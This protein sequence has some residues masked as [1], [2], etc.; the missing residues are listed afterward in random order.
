MTATRGPF[1]SG[2]Y[3][4]A[5]AQSTTSATLVTLTMPV[6][7]NMAFHTLADPASAPV[8]EAAARAPCSLRPPFHRMTGFRRA[9][10]RATSKKRRPS[11]TPSMYATIVLVCSSWPK[12]SR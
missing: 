7:L 4:N 6:C 8:C 3:W 9:T 12:Y 10:S 2:R 11:L 1:G 5:T